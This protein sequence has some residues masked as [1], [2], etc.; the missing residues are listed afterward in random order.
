MACPLCGNEGHT[1]ETCPDAPKG[2]GQKDFSLEERKEKEAEIEEV[3][4]T[5]FDKVKAV[6]GRVPFVPDAVSMYYCML[7][8]RTPFWV[9]ATVAG[10]LLY[11]ISPFDVIPD[12]IPVVG[13]AD[14]AI[15]V[16][17]ALRMVHEHITEEHI[18]R[19]KEW[20]GTA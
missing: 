11:F 10:A 20:L 18:A 2:L 15:V 17:V 8:P 14:D 6:A 7:D 16:Y 1:F 12:A 3:K 13:Y 4:K 9:K 19:A 5:F